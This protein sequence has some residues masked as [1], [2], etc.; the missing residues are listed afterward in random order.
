[1][2]QP[3]PTRAELPIERTWNLDA[4]F[5]SL[6][7]W[8]AAIVASEQRIDAIPAFAGTL[9][10]G[11][12]AWADFLA[13]KEELWT[14]LMKAL[15]WASLQSATDALDSTAQAQTGRAR[16]LATRAAAAMA[17]EEPE[18]LAIGI[19]TLREW[20]REE[21][22]LHEMGHVVEQLARRAAHVRSAEV[23]EVLGLA[24][25][26]LGAAGEAYGMLTNA[27]MDFDPAADSEGDE[28]E[29]AQSSINRLLASPDRVLRQSA[30]RAYADGYLGKRRTLGA[31]LG[32][33]IKRDVLHVRARGYGS[34]LEAATEPGFIP[35]DVCRGMLD[36]F[37]ENLPTWHRYWAIRR[38]AL[39]VDGL[40]PWDVKAPLSTAPVHVGYEQGVE[41]IV[42]GV[43]PLGEEYARTVRAGAL[44]ERW[45]DVLPNRGKRQGAF[46]SGVPGTPP[47]I[48]MSWTDDVFSLS[49]LAHEL[50]HS[51]H[52][53]LTWRAQ[54]LQYGRYGMFVAE[55]ASNLTQ[56]LVRGWLLEETRDDPAMQLALLEEA[57]ANFYRYFFVMPSLARFELAMHERVER[58]QAV[59]A[60]IMGG[61][62][63]DLL[64]E[65]YG[66]Q[67]PFGEDRERMGVTWAQFPHLFAN[68]YV[69]QYATGISA[70]HALAARLLS[71]ES[72]A[73]EDVLGFLSA[74]SSRFPLDALASAGVDMTSRAPVDAAFAA[75][76]DV[77]DRLEAWERDQAV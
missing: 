36:V 34:S 18:L 59:N 30:W 61:L 74:G 52:S 31:C 56:A 38:R 42:S 53:W 64:A 29:V 21:P 1:M 37:A 43:A 28:H 5:P 47:Y 73:R 55:V 4:I 35:P 63:A 60:D 66:D 13:A 20:V 8:E 33:A 50:G 17:F 70:A 24:G 57:M 62:M 23:E 77:V 22:R 51:M 75:L 45:V 41:W 2:S 26:A 54:P 19:D 12:A 49:T 58:G 14:D 71:G 15:V 39:G 48:L 40:R 68:F 46:S 32:G 10:A 16:G 3:L 6:A 25:D 72:G 67:M 11:A 9:H 44:E 65:G 7:A 69:Y 76:G 27:E